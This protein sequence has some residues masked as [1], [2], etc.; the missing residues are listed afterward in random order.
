MCFKNLVSA[1]TARTFPYVFPNSI[2]TGTGVSRVGTQPAVTRHLHTNDL[3]IPESKC[4]GYVHRF[5][6]I[7]F[8][9]FSGLQGSFIVRV[10]FKFRLQRKS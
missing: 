10:F 2:V 5:I 6:F 7:V 9:A 8:C 1:C 3:Y 4:S